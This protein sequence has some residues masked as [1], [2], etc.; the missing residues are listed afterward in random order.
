MS[1]EVSSS[2]HISSSFAINFM[3]NISKFFYPSYLRR[4]VINQITEW[5]AQ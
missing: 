3:L 5:S 2:I 1:G 4:N